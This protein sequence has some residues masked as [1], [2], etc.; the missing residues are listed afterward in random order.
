MMTPSRVGLGRCSSVSWNSK[1][2]DGNLD[3]YDDFNL[4]ENDDEDSD[5]DNYYNDD[6]D[7]KNDHRDSNGDCDCNEI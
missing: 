5:D 3:D 4:D 1:I 7:D 6:S 2:Y